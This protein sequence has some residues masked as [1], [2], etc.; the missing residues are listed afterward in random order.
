MENKDSISFPK[1]HKKPW[2]LNKKEIKDPSP[3]LTAF[4][5]EYPLPDIR[6]S[7][8]RW[9]ER[10][11]LSET[12]APLEYIWFREELE[13]CLEAAFQISKR[14]IRLKNKYTVSDPEILKFIALLTHELNGQFSGVIQALEIIDG[15]KEAHQSECSTKFIEYFNY[16]KILASNTL[17]VLDNM[18]STVSFYEGKTRLIANRST[19]DAD[20][21]LQSCI[22]IFQQPFISD[23]SLI[24][25]DIEQVRELELFTDKEKL[26]QIVHNLLLNAIKHG[27][28]NKPIKLLASTFDNHLIISVINVGISISKDKLRWIFEPFKVLDQGKAGM[29]I[30]LFVCKLYAELLGGRI[31]AKLIQE[32]EIKF[33]LVIPVKL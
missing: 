13:K 31:S 19:F 18:R 24:E 25:I 23:L 17:S 12:P 33:T 15:H 1:W 3:V 20:L 27:T 32:N 30:G 21:V 2:R 10:A 4:F 16:I 29:G 9:Q 8:T 6:E 7:L 26:K 5:R 28:P 11:L 22:S 14:E